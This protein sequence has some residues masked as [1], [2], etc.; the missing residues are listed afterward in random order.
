MSNPSGLKQTYMLLSWTLRSSATKVVIMAFALDLRPY[1]TLVKFHHSGEQVQQCFPA[2]PQALSF[3]MPQR[4]S[5]HLTLANYWGSHPAGGCFHG[6]KGLALGLCQHLYHTYIGHVQRA[7]ASN[8]IARF[9]AIRLTPNKWMVQAG[10][11]SK[12]IYGDLLNELV[13][14]STDDVANL[15]SALFLLHVQW[16]VSYFTIIS[17]AS[18]RPCLTHKLLSKILGSWTELMAVLHFAGDQCQLVTETTEAYLR[19]SIET[20][21]ANFQVHG[22]FPIQTHFH[23]VSTFPASISE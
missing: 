8:A 1:K 5:R 2:L 11:R 14:T 12:R 6:G 22:Q 3:P 19:N 10:L 20:G 23:S 18:D 21:A 17:V 4:L 7:G 9:E 16:L 15:A 13:L